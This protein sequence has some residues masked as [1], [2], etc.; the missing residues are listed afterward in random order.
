MVKRTAIPSKEERD[1]DVCPEPVEKTS[2]RSKSHHVP[3]PGRKEVDAQ[4][5]AA[6][7]GQNR[8]GRSENPL[9]YLREV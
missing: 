8:Q 1:S 2:E 9:R 5:K 7:G 4:S 3:S 6:Q